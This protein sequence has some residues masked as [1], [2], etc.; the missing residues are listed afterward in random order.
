GVP[1]TSRTSSEAPSRPLREGRPW[2][3]QALCFHS[4]KAHTLCHDCAPQRRPALLLGSFCSLLTCLLL[5]SN[6]QDARSLCGLSRL[7][8]TRVSFAMGAVCGMVRGGAETGL[9]APCGGVHGPYPYLPRTENPGRTNP[10][11]LE[12]LRNFWDKNLIDHEID[13]H[14][15]DRHVE[16][17]RQR[18]ARN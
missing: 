14:P 8:V 18:P 10:R 11:K 3:L 6:V 15:G 7:A 1:W 13:D 9:A 12:F 4:D 5:P 17:Q 16:P 2:N